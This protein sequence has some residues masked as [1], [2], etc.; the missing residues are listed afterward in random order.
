METSEGE[1]AF[2]I[3]A[4]ANPLSQLNLSGNPLQGLSFLESKP[5]K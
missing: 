4:Q 2:T 3:S 5:K 1:H